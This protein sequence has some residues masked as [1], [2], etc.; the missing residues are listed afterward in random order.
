MVSKSP[1][2]CQPLKRELTEE[3]LQ[4]LRECGDKWKVT[5]VCPHPL[6]HLYGTGR[7]PLHGCVLCGKPVA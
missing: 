7:G 2:L 6:L 4:F 1:D 3:E 5:G